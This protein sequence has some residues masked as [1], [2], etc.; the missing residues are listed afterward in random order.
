MLL[1]TGLHI[2]FIAHFSIQTTITRLILKTLFIRPPHIIVRTETHSL[3]IKP[4]GLITIVSEKPTEKTGLSVL[5]HDRLIR[6]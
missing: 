6:V 1:L 2:D 5:S 4:W 3:A